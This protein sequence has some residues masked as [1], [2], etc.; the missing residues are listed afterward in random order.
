MLFILFVIFCRFITLQM[1]I[2]LVKELARSSEPL[3]DFTESQYTLVKVLELL[4]SF[5]Q[6]RPL[7]VTLLKR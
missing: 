2:Y 4:I 7:I 1:G 3:L 6:V 5:S